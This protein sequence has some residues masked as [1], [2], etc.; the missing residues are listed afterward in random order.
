MERRAVLRNALGMGLVGTAAAACRQVP[1]QQELG[2]E[3]SGRG[4]SA[5]R[6]DQIRHADAAQ[7]WII[8][9]RA[10]GLMRGTYSRRDQQA[11]VDIVHDARRFTI[12]YAGSTNLKYDGRSIDN[13]YNNYVQRLQRAI[14]EQPAV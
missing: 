1:V 4:S 3:F 7:G 2:G 6:A 8:D 10:P 11:V 12:R 5:M 13:N 14:L 9:T